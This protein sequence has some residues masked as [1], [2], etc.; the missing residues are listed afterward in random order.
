VAAVGLA[1]VP[2]RIRWAGPLVAL[3]LA[4]FAVANRGPAPP[5][6]GGREDVRVQTAYVATHRHPGDVVL[7]NFSGQYGFAYYWSGDRPGFVRGG[8]TA[9]GWYVRFPAASRIVVAADRDP[10]SVTRAVRAA[11]ALAGSGRIWLV[12]SHVNAGEARAW[13]SAL[14]GLPVQVIAVGPEPLAVSAGSQS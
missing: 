8:P 11:V 3:A 7:V 5:P 10:A 2:L 14:A 1:S 6:G 9:T 12:R 13:E 4:G